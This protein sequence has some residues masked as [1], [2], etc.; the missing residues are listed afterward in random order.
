MS[1]SVTIVCDACSK[2]VEVEDPCTWR[3]WME[4]HHKTKGHPNQ[5]ERWTILTGGQFTRDYIVCSNLRCQNDT[6]VGK[7]PQAMT[8]AGYALGDY[9]GF[10]W[11]ESGSLPD[12]VFKGWPPP[13]PG[14]VKRSDEVVLTSNRV[15][16]AGPLMGSGGEQQRN[17]RAILLDADRVVEAGYIPFI[18]HL[19]TFWDLVAP[20]DR[21]HWLR[22]NKHWLMCCGAIVRREGDSVGADMEAE[23]AH[24]MGIPV[25]EVETFLKLRPKY[26]PGFQQWAGHVPEMTAEQFWDRHGTKPWPGEV[27]TSAHEEP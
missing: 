6:R 25:F 17:V 20:H 13:K 8:D 26:D 9:V 22:L 18:P 15:F 2:S 21:N 4:A 14:H 24:S 3:E 5:G 1:E 7:T 27:Q 11:P 19:F 16:M 23:W 12:R 10:F